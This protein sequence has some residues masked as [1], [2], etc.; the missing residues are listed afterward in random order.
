MTT[1]HRA[2]YW[3]ASVSN[4]QQVEDAYILECRIDQRSYTHSVTGR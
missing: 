2:Q 1:S 4:L 3:R